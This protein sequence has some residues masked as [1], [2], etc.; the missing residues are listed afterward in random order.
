MEDALSEF[1]ETKAFFSNRSLFKFFILSKTV[2][3]NS[4][5]FSFLSKTF[6]LENSD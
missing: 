1:E 4:N 3:N 2:F 6:K 5:F